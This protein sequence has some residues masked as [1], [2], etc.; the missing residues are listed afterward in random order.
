MLFT[1]PSHGDTILT[2]HVT[3]EAQKF[4]Y[5]LNFK[6]CFEIRYKNV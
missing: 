2:T 4:K 6:F 5:C 3:T 1:E